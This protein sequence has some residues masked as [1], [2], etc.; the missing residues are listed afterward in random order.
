MLFPVDVAQVPL[1]EPQKMEMVMMISL[2][3][4]V[5]N[6]PLLEVLLSASPPDCSCACPCRVERMVPSPA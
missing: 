6:L 2:A 1:G 5:V 3:S 4:V